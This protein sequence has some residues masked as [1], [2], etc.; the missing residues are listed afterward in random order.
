MLDVVAP[1]SLKSQYRGRRKALACASHEHAGN[2]HATTKRKIKTCGDWKLRKSS[3][4]ATAFLAWTRAVRCRLIRGIS[5]QPG[6]SPE[7]AEVIRGLLYT[8]H[9][10]QLA[11]AAA[12]SLLLIALACTLCAKKKFSWREKNPGAPA[13]VDVEFWVHEESSHHGTAG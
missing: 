4:A 12:A 5:E 6:L 7:H 11:F 3:C 10:G 9:N 13:K 2:P 8:V 1:L